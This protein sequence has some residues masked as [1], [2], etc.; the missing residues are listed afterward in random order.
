VQ[1]P[2]LTLDHKMLAPPGKARTA[3]DRA[4]S[5]VLRDERD[6]PVLRLF[7]LMTVS[8]LPAVVC[9]YLVGTPPW[10]WLLAVFVLAQYFTAPYILALHVSSHR[11]IFRREYRWLQGF[12]VWVLGP[13]VGQTPETYKAHHMGMHHTEENLEGDLSST[14]PYQ[15]DR[16]GHWLHYLARFLFLIFPELSAY[17][18]S[19]RRYR[20]VR[21]LWAGELGYL[22]VVIGL[23]FLN[24]QVTLWVFVV[25]LFVTRLALMAGNWTQHAFIDPKDPASPYKSC[26][27]LIDT[28]YNRMCFNDGFHVGHHIKPNRHW[29]EM[30][31]DFLRNLDRYAEERAVVIR[32][33]DYFHLWLLL[34]L[35]QHQKIAQHLVVWPGMD[36]SL[37]GRVAW[38]KSR[39]RPVKREAP[40]SAPVTV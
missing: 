32:G 13:L 31:D 40:G 6:L 17:M 34:M 16:F 7:A 18:L 9:S 38:L 19:R 29:S 15:R 4:F 14:M 3:L 39:L 25:R 1:S 35:K 2:N 24:W 10:W 36:D 28:P 11:G 12:V 8:L 27:T 33:L 26:L 30:P 21:R 5:K 20:L 23:L 22:A 37:E